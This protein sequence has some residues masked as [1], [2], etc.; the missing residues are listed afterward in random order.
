MDSQMKKKLLKLKDKEEADRC[1]DI[2]YFYNNYCKQDWEPEINEHDFKIL[3]Q[4]YTTMSGRLR[5]MSCAMMRL[6]K[7]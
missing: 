4:L 5:R 6:A 2:R 1:K 7:D 3:T